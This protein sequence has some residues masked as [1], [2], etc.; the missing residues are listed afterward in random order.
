M[1]VFPHDNDG[2]F[3]TLKEVTDGSKGCRSSG[4]K[5]RESVREKAFCP[6]GALG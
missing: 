4:P 6:R 2:K 3:L 5:D 1:A